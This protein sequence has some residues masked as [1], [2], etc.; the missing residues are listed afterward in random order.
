MITSARN[1]SAA[2]ILALSLAAVA[3]SA[4]AA[5]RPAA[6]GQ[7]REARATTRQALEDC[8]NTPLA[9]FVVDSLTQSTNSPTLVDVD[10][11]FRSFTVGGNKPSCVIVRFSA[12]AF[13]PGIG[14]FIRVRALLD[15]KPSI[16]NEIQMVAESVSFSEA[17]AY[18]FLFPSVSPGVHSVRMQYR[19]PNTGTVSIND[20]NMEIRHR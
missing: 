9:K 1:Y 4:F 17:A 15:G 7:G 6:D 14:E 19:S 13:A 20:F 16:E 5:G 11:S 8:G 3:S 10:R 18:T 2:A 12:Q